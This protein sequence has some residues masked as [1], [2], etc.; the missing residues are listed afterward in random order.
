VAKHSPQQHE[1]SVADPGSDHVEVDEQYAIVG[2][3][4]FRFLHALLGVDV[5]I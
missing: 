5:V 2:Q 1:K 3:K 4:P